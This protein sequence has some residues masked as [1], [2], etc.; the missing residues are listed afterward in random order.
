MY[1][2]EVRRARKEAFKSSSAVVKLQEELKTTRNR[3]TLMREEVEAH[4][5]KME[6]KDQE[7][8]AARYQLIGLQE[9]LESARQRIQITEEE[10]DAMKTSL[11]QEEVARIAAEGKIALPPSQ[12]A[13]EFASPK[14]RRRE[15]LKK[16]VDTVAMEIQL[17][18]DLNTLRQEMRWEKGLRKQAESLIEFMKMECQFRCCSCRLAEAEGA[19]YINDGSFFGPANKKE[20]STS[21]KDIAAASPIFTQPSEPK[22]PDS[23]SPPKPA[24]PLGQTTEMLIN[25]SPSADTYLKYPTPINGDLLDLSYLRSQNFGPSTTANEAFDE[26]PFP[27]VPQQQFSKSVQPPEQQIYFDLPPRTPR[28]L[29]DPPSPTQQAPS[30]AQPGIRSATQP[31]LRSIAFLGS[32]TTTT[33]V[34]LASIPVSPD[35]TISRDEALEQI[36]QRRGRAR[37]AAGHGT[38]RKP[39]I[40][41]GAERRDLSAPAK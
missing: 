5:R 12:E 29:P 26:Y 40:G 24:S 18:S 33:T 25:F 1:E 10:R 16:D 15:S 32:T 37:S 3:A 21:A 14:K 36:R 20:P 28:A 27:T 13:D 38:P 4:K 23:S 19:E 22:E 31:T 6:S 34:P 30:I 2:K 41:P 11:Q 35:K 17:P 7:A 39:M 8:F 9:Q